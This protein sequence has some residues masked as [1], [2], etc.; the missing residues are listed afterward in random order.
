V[1]VADEEAA[2]EIRGLGV[3]AARRVVDLEAA[4]LGHGV[5]QRR[6][7]GQGVDPRAA[8]RPS[9]QTCWLATD[10]RV[11]MTDRLFADE[12]V[13]ISSATTVA[14]LGKRQAPHVE[15]GRM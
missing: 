2:G 11:S 12:L 6:G 15:P 1:A 5:Q 3:R 8:R 10:R 14:G 4:R 9:S 13:C 7:A